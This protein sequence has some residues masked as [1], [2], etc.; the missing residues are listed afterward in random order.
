ME[1]GCGQQQ[2]SPQIGSL[3]DR[4][5]RDPAST[6]HIAGP[7]A[8]PRLLLYIDV[9][10][11]PK[12]AKLR[13]NNKTANRPMRH[14]W[15]T[16]QSAGRRNIFPSLGKQRYIQDACRGAPSHRNHICNSQITQHC[17]YRLLWRPDPV[18]WPS[19]LVPCTHGRRCAPSRCTWTFPT[20]CILLAW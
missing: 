20:V 3:A 14:F 8:V 2:S 13:I 11:S 18:W 1:C 16:M 7:A 4:R 10:F 12:C 9:H 6:C 5:G 17:R 15:H 19:V